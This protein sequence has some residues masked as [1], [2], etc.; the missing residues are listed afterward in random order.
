[1]SNNN[2]IIVI[3]ESTFGRTEST[4]GK[5]SGQS[6]DVPTST[7]VEGKTTTYY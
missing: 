6:P 1:M 5:T 2:F 4:F 3:T 7:K